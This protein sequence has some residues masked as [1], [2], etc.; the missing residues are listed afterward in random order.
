MY[1]GTW[2]SGPVPGELADFE[3]MR[4]M[5]WSW[6]QLQ[7]TPEYVRRYCWDFTLARRAAEQASADRAKGAGGGE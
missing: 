7:A 3:V 5:H 4:E 6:D 1:E 2:S